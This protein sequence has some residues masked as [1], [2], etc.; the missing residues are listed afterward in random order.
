MIE[1]RKMSWAEH[2]A[3][4]WA[5]MNAYKDLV[6]KTKRKIQPGRYRG[7]CRNNITID[8]REVE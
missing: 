6:V 3:R 5:K 7:R 8:L 2:V 4:F 1:S